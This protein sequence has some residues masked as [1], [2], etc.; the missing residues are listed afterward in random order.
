MISVVLYSKYAKS[1]RKMFMWS[2]LDGI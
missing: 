2:S 1:A